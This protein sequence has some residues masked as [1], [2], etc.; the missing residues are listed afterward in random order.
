MVKPTCGTFIDS[1]HRTNV[2]DFFLVTILVLDD[3]GEGVPVGWTISNHK[4]TAVIWEF[5]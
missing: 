4:D 3:F 5:C 2:Y 1:T